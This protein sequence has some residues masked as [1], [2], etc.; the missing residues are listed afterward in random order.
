MEEEEQQA[1]K[2]PDY[3]LR[4]AG[5]RKLFLEAKKPAVSVSSNKDA[6][7]QTRRYGWNARMPMS[8]LSNFEKLVIYDCTFRPKSRDDAHVARLKVFDVSEYIEKFDEIYDSLSRE[9][10][11]S[12]RFDELYN[13][14]KE[15]RGAEVFDNYFL[16]EIEK[17][18]NTLARDLLTQNSQLSEEELNFLVQR[19]INRVIF[20][21]I[22]EDR[23]LE[24]YKQ[25]E[26][27]HSYEE[28]KQLF[29][30]ADTKYN[31]GLFDF[32]EDQLSFDI[33]VS[34]E[35]LISIFRELYLPQ[36]PY[37][38]SV[39]DTNIIG[40]IYERF[41]G[42][43]IKVGEGNTIELVPRPEVVESHG[44]VATPSSI[45]GEIV[46]RTL[47][48]LCRNK[49]PDEL[50]NI[51]VA[52]IACGSGIF[53]LLA[54][55]YL[56]N[57]HLDW[58][59]RNTPQNYPER[60]YEKKGNEW[61][62]SLAEKQRVLLN[63]IFGVD[64]DGQAVEISRF[65]LLLKV[66]EGE[67]R[68]TVDAHLGATRKKALP[69]LKENIK[70]GNSLVDARFYDFMPDVLG[71]TSFEGENIKPFEWD[72]AFPTI[73]GEGGFSAIIGN[74]PYIRIQNM[75]KFSP[76][77]V[78]YYKYPAA[79]FSTAGSNNFDKYALFIE[80]ALHL[81]RPEGILGYIVPNKFFVAKYG[82]AL[83]KMLSEGKH[84]TQIIDFGTLQ[85]FKGK[86]T[87]TCI[88]VLSKSEREEFTYQRVKNISSWLYGAE[89]DLQH[90]KA[91]Y[92]SEEPWVFVS[93]KLEAIFR[94]I[95]AENPKMLGGRG[96]V[97]DVF[98]GLQ[99]S[100]DKVYILHPLA[101]HEDRVDFTDI[102]GTTRSIERSILLP[103]LQ[104]VSLKCFEKP[105]AN[106]YMIFPYKI[107]GDEALL[108]SPQEMQRQFPL[109]WEYLSAF[110]EDLA[111]RDIQGGT[112][113]TWYQFGRSQNLTKFN[114]KPKLIW[115][116]LSIEPAYTL[117]D[118]NILITGGG[119]GPYYALRPREES[120]SI[121][122]LHAILSHPLIEIMIRAGASMF[123]GDYA[124]HGK[125]Y[126]EKVPIHIIDEHST[127]ERNAYA[128]IVDFVRRLI[129]VKENILK[130]SIPQRRDELTRQ[131]DILRDKINHL[132][133][134]L[135]KLTSEEEE[136]IK[137]G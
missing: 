77:E 112:S 44:V 136:I 92:L 25:L 33:R 70:C 8:V 40:E 90:Y 74:P 15:R 7:F 32:I 117:D 79:N 72:R 71:A 101:E 107:S 124:S 106:A 11:F 38:F 69:N 49:S 91:E 116:V 95:R 42:N 132:V 51:R 125:Q 75:V 130:E 111:S 64:I 4:V 56:L 5:I 129:D 114:G 82:G 67:S 133:S 88:L 137:A 30:D 110:K 76:V 83:R 119:N 94:R 104:D 120:T 23:E 9:S 96:G 16:E 27:V 126:V 37:A 78:Q 26:E 123:R 1:R 18:R 41:L 31:S 57:Q 84:V 2:K 80:R 128:Q 66:L 98:V 12:G 10:V 53:L 34:S 14:E 6:A 19:L 109:C 55:E 131:A 3:T 93:P 20:L 39:V 46:R 122:Y 22:C 28:L 58:Y 65:S 48:P 73:M 68:A 135:Y 81:L 17:W 127:D 52:D 134:G 36:S 118:D 13:I 62:L 29:G 47:E 35:V 43:V 24:T 87:Y 121:Y 97:A 105:S 108:L 99:T 85:V 86:S 89:T 113:E 60:L 50:Q 59:I 102:T 54:Y 45:A 100:R 21:R 103:C 63:N 61:C 115:P